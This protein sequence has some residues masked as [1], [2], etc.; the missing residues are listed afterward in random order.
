MTPAIIFLIVSAL[1]AGL[2]LIAGLVAL[3]A[4]QRTAVRETTMDAVGPGRRGEAPGPDKYVPLAGGGGSAIATWLGPDRYR[5]T[6]RAMWWATI[7]GVLISIGV[8]DAFTDTQVQVFALAGLAVVGVVVFHEL[9]PDR[10]RTPSVSAAEALAAIA[11]IAG[12]IVLTGRSAS[13]YAPLLAIPVLAVGL[14]G[15]SRAGLAAAAA[16]TAAY[17]VVLATDP[18]AP[19][20]SAELLAAVVVLGVVWLATVAAVVFAAQQRRVQ[21]ATLQLSITDPLTGLFNRAQIYVDLDQEVRRSRRSLRPFCL[22]MVDMDG[23]KQINDTLGH[24]RGDAAVKGIAGV[25]RRSSRATDSAY[26]YAGDEF[27]VLLPETEFPGAFVVAEKIREGAESLWTAAAG[28]VAPTT[29]SVGLVE[30]PT[31]GS[32]DEELMLAVDRAMYAAKAAGKNQISGYSRTTRP[33]APGPA[34]Q[35]SALG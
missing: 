30:F 24:E 16:A 8:T 7:T 1:V 14:G 29:V 15:Q 3:L 4:G 34:S 20:A 12:L 21:E 33:A 35:A 9:I 2:I 18:S 26:R 25:I 19:F 32:S 31:D 27:V 23:L 11:L 6:V 10:W 13:P 17:V 5:S 28:E 22:L